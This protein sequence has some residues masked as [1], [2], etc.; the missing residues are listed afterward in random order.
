MS[1]SVSVPRI[2]DPEAAQKRKDV[3]KKLQTIS[4][5]EP[6]GIPAPPM[7]GI[8]RQLLVSGGAS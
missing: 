8:D 5:G 2:S 1:Q 3:F 4:R 7:T 6:R